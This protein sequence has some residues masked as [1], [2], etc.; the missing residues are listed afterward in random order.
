MPVNHLHIVDHPL[1]QDMLA[2]ARE[3]R[4]SPPRFRAL[5]RRLG[6]FLAYEALRDVPQKPEQ[7]TTPLQPM[8][9]RKLSAPITAVPILRAGLG[10]T[11]GVLD[12]WPDAKVGHIGLFRDESTLEPVSYYERLPSSISQG[13]VLLIDPMLATGGSACDAIRRLRAKG[14]TDLRFI[15]LV[16]APQGVAKVHALDATIS[17]YTAALDARLNEHGYIVP[18]LG[19]AGDRLYGTGD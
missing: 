10:M 16:A 3:T 19:D 13:P 17:I 8:E 7:I 2:E 11:E 1:V 15:C 9:A 14:C 6:A 5:L 4:T 12:T 18:G